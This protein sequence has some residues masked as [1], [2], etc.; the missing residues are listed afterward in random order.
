M[1]NERFLKKIIEKITDYF[2]ADF[3]Y[4]RIGSWWCNSCGCLVIVQTQI[5]GR[6]AVLLYQR[7]G[8]CLVPHTGSSLRFRGCQ[9]TAYLTCNILRCCRHVRHRQAPRVSTT[10]H[11]ALSQNRL[12]TTSNQRISRITVVHSTLI[13]V[14]RVYIYICMY[15]I[16]YIA[17]RTQPYLVVSKN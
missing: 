9:G 15:Y 4:Q 13:Y 8:C 6:R 3:H 5:L 2:L 12:A 11:K 10:R 7:L 17:E 1:N 14:S 16:L